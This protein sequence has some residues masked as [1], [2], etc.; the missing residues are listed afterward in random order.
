MST[1]SAP[2]RVLLDRVAV[3]TDFQPCAERAL[4]YALG[5]ARHY[6]STLYLVNVLPHL[7]F[8]EGPIPDPEQM[9]LQANLKMSDIVRAKALTAV[10]H[11]ELVLQGEVPKVLGELVAREGIKLIVMGTCGRKGVG[12]LL[13]GSVAEDVFR[14]ATCPV[15]T[16]GPHVPA[17]RSPDG[18]LHHILL[19]TDFGPESEHA[20]PYALSLAEENGA[21]LTLLHVEREPGIV[22]PEPEPG[23][24][25]VVE[26]AE[27]MAHAE[28]RLRRLLPHERTLK[29]E[30][31]F[32]VEFGEAAEAI[33]RTIQ[34][35]D[36]DLVVLGARRPRLL[37]THLGMGAAYRVACE[38]PCPV[39]SVAVPR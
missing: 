5:L 38:A 6:D 11:K 28:Q 9:R 37:T 30:P 19:A 20:L 31:E 36:V 26:K 10:K 8:V 34:A 13:L 7:P 17:E 25:P 15:L 24:L 21:R 18:R 27:V 3:A 33:L 2:P 32:V 1:V 39:L 16:V 22:L 29:T 35:L 4:R 23:A 14:H 12:K